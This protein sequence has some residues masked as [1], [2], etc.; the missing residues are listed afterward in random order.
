[1]D[2]QS[3][4][5]R[6]LYLLDPNSLVPP[7]THH[8]V[9]PE[10][11]SSS[12]ALARQRLHQATL[13]ISN[14]SHL[15]LAGM[16]SSPHDPTGA[17]T[18]KHYDSDRTSPHGQMSILAEEKAVIERISRRVPVLPVIVRADELTEIR[19]EATKECVKREMK[20]ITEGLVKEIL[21]D[22][23]TSGSVD[24][25]MTG[26]SLQ[27][28][29][30]TVP[31]IMLPESYHHGDGATLA[32]TRLSHG[33]YVERLRTG[34]DEEQV[35]RHPT[36]DLSIQKRRGDFVRTYRW[37]VVDVLDAKN[38]DFASLR[39]ALLHPRIQVRILGQCT[40]ST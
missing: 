18:T 13:P 14:T 17:S 16:P 9:H 8:L 31:A 37:G 11:Y 7:E 25:P 26:T 4:Y 32:T 24:E 34:V 28:L 39:A 29:E 40:V 35:G 6:C 1:M 3:S 38:S 15:L 23:R 5:D 36:G 33:S 27:R 19:L 10:L 22:S 12:L 2:L 21:D 20:D 30:L